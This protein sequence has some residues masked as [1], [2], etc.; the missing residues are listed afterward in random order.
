MAGSEALVQ[1]VREAVGDGLLGV[2]EDRAGTPVLIVERDFIREVCRLLRDG[3][4]K[5]VHLSGVWGV[6]YLAMGLEPRFAVVYYLYSPS[7]RQRIAIKVPVE[8]SDAVVPSVVELFPGA[9]WHERETFDMYGIRFDGHPNLTRIL[10]PDDADFHP[11]RKDVPIG[12]EA[13]EF[14]HNSARLRRQRAG[15]PPKASLN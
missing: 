15:E 9:N 3:D 12:G 5:Y 4:W 14:T 13:V 10:M 11:L 2:D 7:L 6:D 8:E 1:T